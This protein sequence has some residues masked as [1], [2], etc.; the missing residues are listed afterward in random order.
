MSFAFGIAA[1]IGAGFF[2]GVG[3]TITLAELGREYE[4]EELLDEDEPKY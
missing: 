3:L 4:K 2:I 1:A